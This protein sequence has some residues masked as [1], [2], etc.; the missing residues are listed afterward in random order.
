MSDSITLNQVQDKY[1]RHNLDTKLDSGGQ[2]EV[3]KG[4]FDGDDIVLKT[5]VAEDWEATKRAELEIRAMNDIESDIMVDLKQDFQD[6][7][8]E[9]EVFVMVEELIPGMTLQEKLDQNGPDFQLAAQVGREILTVLQEFDEKEYV[10]RD[11]KPKNIMVQPDGRIRLLDVGIVRSIG[12]ADT[13]VTPTG[14]PAAPG[15]PGFR[16]PEQVVNNKDQQDTR[17]DIFSLGVT[18]FCTMTGAHPFSVDGMDLQGAIQAG[19]HQNLSDYLP[20][21][22]TDEVQELEWFIHKMIE[23]KIYRRFRTPQMTLEE[24]ERI[25]VMFP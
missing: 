25:M 20:D 13:E 7:I 3:F 12:E 4:K 19:I 10:H 15:T 9:R 1:P 23:N 18:M 6:V 2:K 5:I 24:L 17:T 16:A 22:D 14:R 8:G 11:I 21:S